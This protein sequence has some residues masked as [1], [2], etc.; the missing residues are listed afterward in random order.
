VAEA[1]GANAAGMASKWA[2]LEVPSSALH[3]DWTHDWGVSLKSVANRKAVLENKRL[4]GRPAADIARQLGIP[5][6]GSDVASPADIH[7]FRV[8]GMMPKRFIQCVGL[9]SISPYLAMMIDGEEVRAL[10]QQFNGADLRIAL[11]CRYLADEDQSGI[12]K[13]RLGVIVAD[14]A[15][16]AVLAW[17]DRLPPA[18]RGR[19]RLMMPKSTSAA[20]SEL[21]QR[22]VNHN[23][24]MFIRRVAELLSPPGPKEK[25][26][27]AGAW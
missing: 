27:H 14:S 25:S 22:S 21:F 2:V 24:G 4:I 11:A 10:L 12:E 8:M 5:E 6:P 26:E 16:K 15:P 17:A 13:D 7:A 18:M 23:P 9:A 3:A 1:A 19:V 20:Q